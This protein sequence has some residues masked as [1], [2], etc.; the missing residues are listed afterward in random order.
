MMGRV[1]VGP[2]VHDLLL[3]QCSTLNLDLQLFELINLFIHQAPHINVMNQMY[4]DQSMFPSS[5]SLGVCM[6][7]SIAE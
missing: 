2:R 5:S 4:N 1:E 6:C 7:A 3:A